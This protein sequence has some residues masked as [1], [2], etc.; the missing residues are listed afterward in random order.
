MFKLS[1][2]LQLVV[3]TGRGLNLLGR[4]WHVKI[5]LDWTEMCNNHAYVAGFKT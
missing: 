5:R 1:T 4:D 2:H 3:A